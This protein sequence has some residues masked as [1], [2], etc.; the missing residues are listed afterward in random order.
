[1][2]EV[3]GSGRV[4]TF[5]CILALVFKTGWAGVGF[6]E[7][8]FVLANGFLDANGVGLVRGLLLGDTWEG[9]SSTK[10]MMGHAALRVDG[11]SIVHWCGGTPHLIRLF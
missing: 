8:G 9:G 5:F 1:M 10:H 4:L 6:D 3:K 11:T 2:H 7:L